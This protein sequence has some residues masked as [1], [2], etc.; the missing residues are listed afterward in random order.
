MPVSK[1][2][3]LCFHPQMEVTLRLKFTQHNDL[4]AMLLGTGD[5]ELVEV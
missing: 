4:R 5:A 3:H 1:R 2:N